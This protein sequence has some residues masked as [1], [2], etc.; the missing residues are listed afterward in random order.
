M[1]SRQTDK[2][3]MRTEKILDFIGARNV[4]PNRPMVKASLDPVFGLI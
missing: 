4:G 3:V 1:P 2:G